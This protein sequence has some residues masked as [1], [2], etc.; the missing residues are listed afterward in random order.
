MGDVDII[1]TI[2]VSAMTSGATRILSAP[3]E[4]TADAIRERM[5]KRVIAVIDKA[6]AKAGDRP[7]D[8]SDRVAAKVLNEAAWTDDSITAD[9]LGGVL[10]ASGADEDEGASVVAQIG[11]LSAAQLR[12]HYV[13]YREMRRLVEAPGF[14]LFSQRDAAA[15]RL[16]MPVVDLMPLVPGIDLASVLSVLKREGLIGDD[17]EMGPEPGADHENPLAQNLRAVPTGAGAELFLWGHGIRP[18][19]AHR[20]FETDL[21][22]QLLTE[23]IE[24]PCV[25]LLSTP[26]GPPAESHRGEEAE[27]VEV[28]VPSRLL[29]E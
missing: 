6:H 29:L 15:Y 2:V 5:K 18:A 17:T 9:Y 10:A 24:T 3:L 22:L 13:I 8:I 12:L 11:R 26:L 25:S 19:R 28:D 14:N 23:I 20:L 1:T 7:I 21:D 16:R 27:V 4:G